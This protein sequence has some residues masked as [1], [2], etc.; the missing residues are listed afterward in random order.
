M[1]GRFT[2]RS[3]LSVYASMFGVGLNIL[4][5]APRYNVAPSQLVAVCRTAELGWRELVLLHWG[6][7]PHWAKEPKT[8]YSMI[9]ARAETVASK[10]AYRDAFRKRRCLIP[11]DGFYEWRPGKPR[12]QPYYIHRRDGKPFAFAGLWEHWEQGKDTIETCAIIVTTANET[13][14]PI[15]DRMPVILAPADF[16]RW[17]DPKQDAAGLLPL[18]KPAPAG[19]IE[20]YTVGLSV[21]SPQNDGP[22]LIEKV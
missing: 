19:D 16:E 22:G 10:P 17:L 15:H 6:L 13:I 5:G 7:L 4:E 14:A 11:A 1:C 3:P 20:A 9:N 2:Q 18:L 8:S 12:K 21:N